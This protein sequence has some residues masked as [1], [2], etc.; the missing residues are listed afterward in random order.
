MVNDMFDV[1]SNFAA[2]AVASD[3][4]AG[5]L[6]LGAFGMAVGLLRLVWSRLDRLVRRRLSVSV[7]V[8]NRLA[9]Y[10]QLLVAFEARGAFARARRFR[11]TWIGGR[12]KPGASLTPA[13]GRFWF[14]LDG[15]IV[16][17]HRSIDEKSASRNNGRALETLSLVLP[18]GRVATVEDWI[19]EGRGILDRQARIGPR[20]HIHVS[21]YWREAGSVARRPVGSIVAEDDRI[22]RL[23]DDVRWFFGAQEWYTA[24]GVPWRRGYLLH[25]LPGTG[26]SSVIRAVASEVD[27]SLA[28]IDVGRSTL[29]DDAL[30]EA[31]VEAPDR[32]ILVIEDIDAVFSGRDRD[33]GKDRGG[34]SFSGLLNAVDGIGAQE[35]RALFM[36]TNHIEALD[37]AL[38][39]PG[40]ADRHVE[41]GLV[42]PGAAREMF[43]RFFPG[44]DAQ[45]DRF[46]AALQGARLA[47]AAVQGWLL[48]HADDAEA[49]SDATGL[50]PVRLAAE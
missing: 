36:T 9:E 11:L 7:S 41:L 39:R 34:I 22:V 6:A 13:E 5:G 8:D 21:D 37:P 3:F 17:L 12:T 47:P 28:T 29:S 25:G 50:L 16:I 10:R 14:W 44:E 27:L 48:R 4:F 38:I 32:S 43:L 19:A 24:R 15:Q 23:I 49:A 42:G 33:A 46:A 1:L 30:A 26:K 18:F 35:G 2:S 31:L 45:A 40:R 20:L